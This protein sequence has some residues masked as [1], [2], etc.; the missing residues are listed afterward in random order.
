MVVGGLRPGEPPPTAL[1]HAR[2]MP[3]VSSRATHG[4][5]GPRPTPAARPAS[6]TV[7]DDHVVADAGGRP[8]SAQLRPWGRT[9][10]Q[11]RQPRHR[12]GRGDRCRWGG[13]AGGRRGTQRTRPLAGG[14]QRLRASRRPTKP[15]LLTAPRRVARVASPWVGRDG[16]ARGPPSAVRRPLRDPA[17]PLR[18]PTT[19]TSENKKRHSPRG[20]SE[21]SCT[22]RRGEQPPQ[23]V[24]PTTGRGTTAVNQSR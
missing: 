9:P 13:D 8:P 24:G 12:E 15:A 18:V 5:G 23:R 17:H 3:R 1:R 4:C 22:L 21:V 7:A 10:K 14:A 16:R 6:A 2:P 19:S 11:H 20:S